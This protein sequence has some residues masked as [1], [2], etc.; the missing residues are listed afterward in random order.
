[1]EGHQRNYG[2]VPPTPTPGAQNV[3]LEVKWVPMF[4][5][6]SGDLRTCINPFNIGGWG[7]IFLSLNSRE[8]LSELEISSCEHL[9]P[10][11]EHRI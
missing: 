6:V 8:S 10:L 1:M 2:P 9:Q 5:Q 7:F 3:I 11:G 4:T